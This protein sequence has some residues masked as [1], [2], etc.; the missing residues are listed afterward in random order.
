MDKEVYYFYIN[1]ND[2][3]LLRIT[4]TYGGEHYRFT[5]KEFGRLCNLLG[6]EKEDFDKVGRTI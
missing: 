1:K 3:K 5:E 6:F 2:N 4:D